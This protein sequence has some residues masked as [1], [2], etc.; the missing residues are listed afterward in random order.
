MEN[1]K[2]IALAYLG[3]KMIMIYDEEITENGYFLKYKTKGKYS[4]DTFTRG[5]FFKEIDGNLIE[6]SSVKINA[7]TFNHKIETIRATNNQKLFY[8]L[9]KK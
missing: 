1:L 6:I 7:T 5:L 2:K 8:K 4:D 3:E 9:S